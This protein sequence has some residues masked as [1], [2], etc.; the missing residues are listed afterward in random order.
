M[1]EIKI[2]KNK[3]SKK[4]IEASAKESFVDMVKAVVDIEQDM[5]AVGGEL[6][7][8][9]EAVLLE[10]GS[11]QKNIWGINIYPFLPASERVEFDSLI[12]IR[13]SQGNRSRNIEDEEIRKKIIHIVNTLIDDTDA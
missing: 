4:D 1:S 11:K 2:I 9:A 8:D 3:I 5:M 6:H 10:Q 13:P 7:S 12:N